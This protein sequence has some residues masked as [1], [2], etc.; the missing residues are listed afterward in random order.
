MVGIIPEDKIN[1]IRQSIDIVDIIGEYVHLKKQGR[2]Y[3]GLC[4]FHGENTPSFSVSTDKQIYHCFGCGAGG[5]VISF[6]MDID[7]L[8]F[9]EA[10]MKLAEKGKVHLELEKG[11]NDHTS[12]TKDTSEEKQM[13]EAYELLQKFY[14]HLL[15]NTTEGQHALEYLLGRGFSKDSIEKFQIGYSLPSWDF[16]VKWLNKRGFQLPLLEKA[17]LIIKRESDE[18]YFDRFRNRIMF[19]IQN[20]KGETI[21]FAGRAIE[22]EDQPKYLNSPETI[23]FNKSNILYNYYRAKGFIKK[24]QQAILFEGFADVISAD[25]AEIFNGIATMGTSLTEQHVQLI[26]RM[27]D[28][29]TIC[30]DSDF[31][32]I[33]AA[34][35][36]GKM[37][38]EQNCNIRIARMPEGL[39][40][41]DYIKKYGAEKF[42]QDVIG[43]SLTFMS[44]KMEY[45]RLGK[46]LQNEGEKLQYIEKIIEE[47]TNLDKAV[48]R[49]HYL[50]QLADEFSISLD[51]LKQQQKQM[52]YA[53]KKNRHHQKEVKTKRFY[54]EQK[55]RLFPAHH[56]AERRLL[57]HMLQDADVAFKIKELLN[58]II[59]Y[60]DEHQAILTYLLGFYEEGNEPNTSKFLLI[61]P[62]EKLRGIV[63]ELEMMPLNSEVTDREIEDYVY[64]VL[65]HQK[66][67]KIKEKENLQKKAEQ[68]NDREKALSLAVEILQLRKSL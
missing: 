58:G 37:L 44:F 2:N 16:T 59:L 40:P 18:S 12:K 66:M 56:T 32:G 5:N 8:S 17:G 34:Y 60:Y 45:F 20:S 29:V 4:P 41:D 31:A 55:N 62:D 33:E 54:T 10:V 7:G 1:E 57:A 15:V 6:L 51:A 11:L 13:K 52:F 53:N 30:Y 9:Q 48:E 27:T 61:L 42:R 3:F 43:A 23:L 19:P 36:A 67:L 21:A 28:S 63:T 38:S 49:D 22:K 25:T 64:Q 35:R 68:E 14:H 46:N 26:R 39:D 24:Q 65:K 47:I 50:R